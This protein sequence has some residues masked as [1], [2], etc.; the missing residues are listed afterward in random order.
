MW[1]RYDKRERKIR[2]TTFFTHSRSVRPYYTRHLQ[3]A[4][5]YLN[6]LTLL[7]MFDNILTETVERFGPVVLTLP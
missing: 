4:R 6:N 3:D 2:F 1:I 7:P 5:E